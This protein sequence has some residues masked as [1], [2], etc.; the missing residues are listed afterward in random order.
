MPF[1]SYVAELKSIRNSGQATEN[2]YYTALGSLIEDLDPSVAVVINP[3]KTPHGSPD[4]RLT[5]KK[6]V[7]DF[8]VGW[9][10]AKEP[11]EDLNKI[12]RSDQP[13]RYYN[14]PNL[15]LTD[16]L[17]FRWYTGRKLGYHPRS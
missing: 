10:E 4:F 13:K 1:K 2:S 8:P 14:L 16:F 7:L 3:K 15:I 12:A 6:N 11:G 17:E 9:I 5:R